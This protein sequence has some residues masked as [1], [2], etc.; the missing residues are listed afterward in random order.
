MDHGVLRFVYGGAAQG[1]HLTHHPDVS[2]VHLTGSSDT[3]DA[4]V[5]GKGNAAK[6]GDPAL[7]KPVLAEL[8]NVVRRRFVVCVGGRVLAI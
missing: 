1:A 8:G 6:Q 7:T 4:I 3:Y 2:A 5:W